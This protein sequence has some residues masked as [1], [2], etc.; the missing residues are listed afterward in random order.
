MRAAAEEHP[1]VREC[2][3]CGETKPI[4]EFTRDRKNQSGRNTLCKVCTR[5][6]CNEQYAANPDKYRA[7]KRR[8]YA[9]DPDK[10]NASTLRW[11]AANPEAYSESCRASERRRRVANPEGRRE[12]KRLAA[13]RRRAANPEEHNERNRAWRANNK[14]KRNETKRAYRHANPTR[15]KA[16]DRVNY[17]VKTGKLLRPDNCSKC[18]VACVPHGHH[19]DYSKPLDVVW[20]CPKCHTDVHRKKD[21]RVR[22]ASAESPV[23]SA[24]G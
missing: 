15:A 9:A 12:S 17:A 8:Q 3:R 11:R 22:V 23:P 14:E 6:D 21:A 20:F 13:C 19:A 10:H 1:A 24:T 5:R 2:R 16:S 18:G 4:E 7:A